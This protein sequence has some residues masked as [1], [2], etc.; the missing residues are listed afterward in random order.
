MIK[1]IKYWLP[2]T[3][4]FLSL[5]FFVRYVLKHVHAIPLIHLNF[6]TLMI[7]GISVLLIMFGIILASWVWQLLLKDRDTKMGFIHAQIIF[8]ISQ[9]GKYLPGNI[10]QFLGRFM[11]AKKMNISNWVVANTMLIEIIW[12][13]AVAIFLSSL[14][15]FIYQVNSISFLPQLNLLSIFFLGVT[16]FSSP[17]VGIHLLNKYFSHFLYRISGVKKLSAPQ[18]VTA[19]SVVLLL[20]TCFLIIGSVLKLQAEFLFHSNRGSIFEL[21]CLFPLAWLAG[22]IIPGSPAG[23]GIRE[24]MMVLILS[25]VLGSGVATGLSLSLRITTV[26]AEFLSLLVGVYLKHKFP[27]KPIK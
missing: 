4:A 10:G 11:M 12:T 18:F 20:T 8:S 27:L 15:L 14:S 16:I 9:F 6:L 21:T 3:L 17:W 24:V 26:I 7:F 13:L 19:L 25:P 23:I 22:Y 2:K 5:V 1:Y